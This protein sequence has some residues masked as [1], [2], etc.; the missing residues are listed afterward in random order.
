MIYPCGFVVLVWIHIYVCN[1]WVVGAS[2]FVDTIKRVGV[3]WCTL[4][5]S[6][7]IDPA[8]YLEWGR[9]TR[10]LT[11]FLLCYNLSVSHVYACYK[12]CL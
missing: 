12:G 10:F 11:V 6:C 2:V 4:V 1:R 3:W 8:S 7:L 9:V 5:G